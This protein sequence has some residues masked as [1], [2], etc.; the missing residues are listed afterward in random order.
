M[1][2]KLGPME[3]AMSKESVN[4]SIINSL[5][6]FDI[7]TPSSSEKLLKYWVKLPIF[8]IIAYSTK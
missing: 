3:K 6:R 7:A 2:N 8:I 4:K 5:I 1:E